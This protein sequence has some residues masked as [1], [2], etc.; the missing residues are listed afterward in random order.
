M[1]RERQTLDSKREIRNMIDD[2]E[3]TG[4]RPQED[5]ERPDTLK[6]ARYVLYSAP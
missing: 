5:R 1:L 3:N 4:V 6:I 2:G